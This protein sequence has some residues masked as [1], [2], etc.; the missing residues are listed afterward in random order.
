MIRVAIPERIREI[1]KRLYGVRAELRENL[2]TKNSKPWLLRRAP[3]IASWRRSQPRGLPLP[4]VC[5]RRT[6]RDIAALAGEC[7]RDILATYGDNSGPWETWD[8]AADN[9]HDQIEQVESLRPHRTRLLPSLS[10]LS[11]RPI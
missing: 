1:Y 10:C 4:A 5:L 9:L 6:D 8:N 11:Q 3:W 7:Y 2:G